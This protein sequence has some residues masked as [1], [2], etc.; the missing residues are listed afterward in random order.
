MVRKINSGVRATEEE[1]KAFLI[2]NNLQM[3]DDYPGAHKKWQCRCKKC[4][5]IIG[6]SYASVNSGQGACK[7]CANR[8]VPEKAAIKLLKSRGLIPLENFLGSHK[9]WKVSC[10]KCG[11]EG[12]TTFHKVSAKSKRGCPKCGIENRAE[13]LKMPL[14]QVD[15]LLKSKK[16]KRIANYK[17]NQIP[18]SCIC[19]V[20]K[21]EVSPRVGNLIQGHQG[22]LVCTYQN[23]NYRGF[24]L[25]KPAI[26]YICTSTSFNAHKIGISTSEKTRIRRL[27]QDGWEVL[28]KFTFMNGG[29]AMQIEQAILR[30]WR[31]ELNLPPFVPNNLLKSGAGGTETVSADE[32][33][34]EQIVSKVK[35]LLKKI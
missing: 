4:K 7:Y 21:S 10:I 1:L 17:N 14:K 15:L 13:R 30:W 16:L 5:N 11:W 25:D 31:Q 28:E 34:I 26:L 29:E 2:K 19:L 12:K 35:S 33:E 24:D 20:C 6:V 18:L 9:P 3:I 27:N 32:I 8:A 23:S 22:C